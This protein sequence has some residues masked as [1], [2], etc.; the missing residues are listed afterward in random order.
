MK[1][2]LEDLTLNIATAGEDGDLAGIHN[3]AVGC[4][5]GE[6]VQLLQ[7]GQ[8][9][10]ENLFLGFGHVYREGPTVHRWPSVG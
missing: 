10:A 5:V 7:E 9:A 8:D 1:G 6:V 3:C 2:L 4:G